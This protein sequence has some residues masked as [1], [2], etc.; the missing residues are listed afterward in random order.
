[1]VYGASALSYGLISQVPLA[2]KIQTYRGRDNSFVHINFV[3]RFLTSSNQNFMDTFRSECHASQIFHIILT[4]MLS[5]LA[6]R[7]VSDFDLT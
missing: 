4:R 5:D 7:G 2:H 1:M 3:H 6:N